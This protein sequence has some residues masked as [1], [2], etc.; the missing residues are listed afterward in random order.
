MDV[1]CCGRVVS[2]S[3]SFGCSA[4]WASWARCTSL[5]PCCTR[6]ASLIASSP[7]SLTSWYVSSSC[8][9]RFTS[10][11]RSAICGCV[12]ARFVWLRTCAKRLAAV[13]HHVPVPAVRQPPAVSLLGRRCR[14]AALPQRHQAVRVACRQPVPRAGG[15]VA[16]SSAYYYLVEV[17]LFLLWIVIRHADCVCLPRALKV[18]IITLGERETKCRSTLWRFSSLYG[19]GPAHATS[20]S[21][22]TRSP[23]LRHRQ[24]VKWGRARS[25]LIVHLSR[26]W[27]TSLGTTWILFSQTVCGKVFPSGPCALCKNGKTGSGHATPH[28]SGLM[29][30]CVEDGVRV[31]E[32]V[33]R[34]GVVV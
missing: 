18:M 5:A 3:F 27:W 32:R 26:W 12:R 14:G 31:P 21:E 34:L 6:C 33:S 25:M 11:S 9:R 1:G 19:R 10:S 24:G 2:C 15:A 13:L 4:N 22:S 30:W 29:Q 7:A 23:R 20:S 17:V 16:A 8:R 28:L